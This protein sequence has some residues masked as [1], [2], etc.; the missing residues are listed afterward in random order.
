MV[1]VDFTNV[2]LNKREDLLMPSRDRIREGPDRDA[3][4]SAL[5][6]FLH[7]H[8]GL[9]AFNE[10]RRQEELQAVFGGDKPLEK[11]L[12]KLLK[13]SPS[14]ANLFGVGKQLSKPT[15]FDW[16]K[17]MGNYHGKT[18]PTF[19]RLSSGESRNQRVPVNI[20]YR[21][22]FETDAVNDY[23][24]RSRKPGIFV[25]APAEVKKSFKLWNGIATLT[26]KPPIGSVPGSK[27]S[28]SATVTD[29]QQKEPFPEIALELMVDPPSSSAK[30]N[31]Y[32]GGE[33][34]T[35]KGRFKKSTNGDDTVEGLSLPKIE[36]LIKGIHAT[37]SDHFGSEDD[38]CDV[39]PHGNQ[40][41]IYV[42][43]SN[44]YLQAEIGSSKPGEKFVLENQFKYGLALLALAMYHD[45]VGTTKQKPESV[46]TTQDSDQ[47]KVDILNEIRR[48]S[49]G[50]SMVIL[51]LTNS[52]DAAA[53][54]AS[55]S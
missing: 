51:P 14:L 1:V 18:F 8:E 53:K 50:A 30:G 34:D 26:V 36:G 17:R 10:K 38:A 42:N 13:H 12:G 22:H 3:I 55:G 43:M 21:F 4:E 37:W 48:A 20:V 28:I 11:V 24:V 41:D 47:P 29:A 40:L 16:A 25:M 49:R 6:D 39:V 7:D 27:I 19:F 44:P 31:V 32:A 33:R 9:R 2:P 23:F 46:T 35:R 45:H 52:L 54:S 15:G 5:E